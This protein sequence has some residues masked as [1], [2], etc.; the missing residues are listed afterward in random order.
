MVK[1]NPKLQEGLLLKGE[2]LLLMEQRCNGVID[3]KGNV[4]RNKNRHQE[5]MA[6]HCSI[7]EQY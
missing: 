4:F 7:L 1:Q 6:R 3:V 2:F 5:D